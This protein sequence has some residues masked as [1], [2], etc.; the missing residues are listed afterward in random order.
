MYCKRE[1][2]RSKR[3]LLELKQRVF[4][5]KPSTKYYF[6]PLM[7][8]TS[9]STSTLNVPKQK[10]CILNQ[11]ELLLVQHNLD[12]M[13]HR[14]RRVE[15]EYDQYK[16]IFEEELS[17]MWKNHRNLVKD[18]GMTTGLLNL[19]ERRIQV[20][21]NR[22]RDIYNYKVEYFLKNSY[23][24][25]LE[26]NFINETKHSDPSEYLSNILMTCQH[27]L[28]EKQL[29]LLNRGPTYVPP[30]QMYVSSSYESL[31]DILRKQY[32]PLKHQLTSV[33]ARY[34]IN[35]ALSMEIQKK[36]FDQFKE[37][38]SLSVPMCVQERALYEKR[39]IHTI[40]SSLK[41]KNLLLR[42]TA[43]LMNT[44][45]ILNRQHYDQ[46]SNRYVA[47]CD[48]YKLLIGKQD[49][50]TNEQHMQSELKELVD[51]MNILLESLQ[52]HKSLDKDTIKRLFVDINKIQLPHLYFLPDVSKVRILL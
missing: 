45:V 11:D 36:V 23:N 27:P 30:C 24:N 21:E 12:T 22:W 16:T 39:L 52:R 14:L 18:R 3:E 51:S 48:A 28:T 44:F 5:N 2:E 19:L 25:L 26:I 33:F 17:E 46:L 29:Q 34:R 43:D 38:F 1:F 47:K 31:D 35:I 10:S 20:I 6:P 32:A 7:T 9:T 49:E 40:R 41:K 8:S 13:I 37:Q 50:N 15:L 42:R 4:Y